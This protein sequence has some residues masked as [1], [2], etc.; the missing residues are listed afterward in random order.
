MSE[1]QQGQLT[2]LIPDRQNLNVGTERG[3]YAIEKSIRDYGFG[4]P[5]VA[6]KNGVIIAGNH[7]LE[8]AGEI[9]ME[10][11]IVVESEGDAIIVHRRKD[12]DAN[13]AKTRMLAIADNRTSELSLK[14][15]TDGLQEFAEGTEQVLD[16]FS[17]AELELLNNELQ[18]P[19]YEPELQ[20]TQGATLTT[21][22]DVEAAQEKMNQGFDTAGDQDIVDVVCPH[23]S[24]GF[25]ISRSSL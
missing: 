12:L 23:C 11:V 16:F 6:D 2:D 7:T 4:R 21:D 10:K 1:I 24:K 17:D 18:A 19:S 20:P 8:V 9:G 13:D 14:W 25:G 22:K 15:D 5:L 3:R